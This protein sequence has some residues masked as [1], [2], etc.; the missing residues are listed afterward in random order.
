MRTTFHTLGYCPKLSLLYTSSYI[1][2]QEFP[3]LQGK[4]YKVVKYH[5]VFFV[6]HEGLSITRLALKSLYLST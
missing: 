5:M 1:Y 2:S 4:L 3:T 6:F